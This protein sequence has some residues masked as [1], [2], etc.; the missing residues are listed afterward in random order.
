LPRPPLSTEKFP[1]QGSLWT[2]DHRLKLGD[3]DGL[4][5]RGLEKGDSTWRGQFRWESTPPRILHA[6]ETASLQR[7]GFGDLRIVV[8]SVAGRTLMFRCCVSGSP[9]I[10]SAAA[11]TEDR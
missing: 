5:Y 8:M 6:G 4:F 9:L 11:N 3:G 7:T 10:A 1:F 2:A